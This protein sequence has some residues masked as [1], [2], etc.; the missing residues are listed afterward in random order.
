MDR[1]KWKMSEKDM[2]AFIKSWKDCEAELDLLIIRQKIRNERL[3]K[4]LEDIQVK[5]R[6]LDL[7]P[8]PRDGK[9]LRVVTIHS[10]HKLFLAL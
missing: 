9:F 5:G 4:D 8:P 6:G 3:L 2:D 1:A 10:P 7:P